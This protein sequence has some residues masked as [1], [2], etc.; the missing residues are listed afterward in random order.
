MAVDSLGFRG[1][2]SANPVEKITTFRNTTND[3]MKPSKTLFLIGLIQLIHFQSMSQPKNDKAIKATEDKYE[4]GDYRKAISGLEKFKSKVFKKLGP[5]NAYTAQYHYL[6]A[7]YHLGAGKIT[8][9]E[10]SVQTAISTSIVTNT[11]NSQKHG[12]RVADIAELYILNGSYRVAKDYLTV[13]KKILDDGK[14]WTDGIKARWN[15][16]QA[17]ALTGQGYYN[18]AISVLHDQEKYFAARAV[19]TETFVDDKGNLKSQRVPDDQ[20]KIRYQ[21][22]ARWMTDL[23]NAYRCQ[24]NFNSAD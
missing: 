15:V 14:F 5:Q 1:E 18:G 6:M 22:Y 23:G 7:K 19:K 12:Q 24:G 11:E 13:S 20:L 4:I 10:S 17:E 8:D 21:E 9:F 16:L 2:N 3:K